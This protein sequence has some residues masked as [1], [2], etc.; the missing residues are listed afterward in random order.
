MGVVTG[1]EVSLNI[2]HEVQYLVFNDRRRIARAVI[3][4]ALKIS[5]ITSGVVC[6]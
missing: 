5:S 4:T 2:W 6:T 3:V 1:S